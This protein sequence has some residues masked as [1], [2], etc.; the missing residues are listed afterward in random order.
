MRH[1]N[2]TTVKASRLPS[3]RRMLA[4]AAAHG[5]YSRQNTS[6]D[7]VAAGV[8]NACSVAIEPPVSTLSVLTTLSLARNPPTSE[9]AMR[10]SPKPTGENTGATSEAMFPRILSDWSSTSCRCH[11]KLCRNQMARVA[12]KMTVKAR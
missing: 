12:R 5:V 8:S 1:W 7:S 4:M 11:E 10:Q 3:S 6:N 2:I 9:V